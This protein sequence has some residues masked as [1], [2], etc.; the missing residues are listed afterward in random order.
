MI[1]LLRRSCKQ[2]THLVLQAEDRALPLRERLAVRLH[3]LVCKACPR[4]ADQVALM[5][6]AS[7]RW[8]A[9]SES[10]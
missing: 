8:R 3:M 1:M 10:E 4:F 7:K 2:V 6:S 5:R 9:Y